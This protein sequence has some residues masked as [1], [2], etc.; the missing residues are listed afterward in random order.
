LALSF[1]GWGWWF[2]PPL[3]CWFLAPRIGSPGVFFGQHY[4]QQLCAL[5]LLPVGLGHV[6]ALGCDQPGVMLGQQ[7]GQLSI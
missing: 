5:P 3:G 7:F 2:P 6:P 4:P 1:I